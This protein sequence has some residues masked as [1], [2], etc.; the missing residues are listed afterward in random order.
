MTLARIALTLLFA[1]T[2]AA[3]ARAVVI[4]CEGGPAI[5]GGQATFTVGFSVEGEE[6]VAGT[7]NDIVFNPDIFELNGDSC[8]INPA[9]GDGTEPGKTLANN[10]LPDPTRLVSLVLSLENVV[11][12]PVG[13]LYSCTFDV[14]DD[15]PLGTYQLVNTNAGASNPAGDPLPATGEDCVVEVAEATPTPTPEC[16]EDE[17][18]PPGQVCVNEEC[19]VATP[20][21]TPPGY[22]TDNDDCPEGQV[23]VNNMCVTATPTHTPIGYCT[24]NDDC[25]AG[26]VCVNNMCVTATPTPTP[27]GYCTDEEDC[28]EGQVCVNNMCVTPTPRSSG[29]GGCSCEIDRNAPRSHAADV[30]AVLLPALVLIVRWRLRRPRA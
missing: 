8:T 1:L 14:A 7:Q 17:D 23:C 20:T 18:C 2:S 4:T 19:V 22:C 29:G 27:I 25:P 9:I 24:D 28:P 13:A 10:L 30:L 21:P 16:T 12:I 11:P 6:V 3:T 26:Q 15:A 5:P